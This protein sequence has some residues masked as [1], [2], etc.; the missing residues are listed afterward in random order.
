MTDELK[1]EPSI[2]ISPTQIELWERCERN[3][4]YDRVLK[5]RVYQPSKSQAIGIDVENRIQAAHEKKQDPGND[6]NGK[7]AQAMLELLPAFG[8]AGLLFQQDMSFPVPIGDG[9]R[10]ALVVGKKDLVISGV[11]V[12]DF[13]TTKSI[14]K[15][16]K[17]PAQLL[18]DIQPQ[19]YALD[20]YF[21]HGLDPIPLQWTYGQTEGTT[22]AHPVRVS[23]PAEVAH[24]AFDRAVAAATRM[25]ELKENVPQAH[26]TKPNTQACDAYGG[27]PHR[28]YCPARVSKL[29]DYLPK[30]NDVSLKDKLKASLGLTTA[31]VLP[32]EASPAQVATLGAVKAAELEKTN[33]A[34][35][36]ALAVGVNP[37]DALPSPDDQPKPVEVAPPPETAEFGKRKRRTKAEMEAV[38]ATEAL[39][40]T[41]N[42][43]AGKPIEPGEVVPRDVKALLVIDG[44]AVKG[45]GTPLE[46]LLRQAAIGAAKRAGVED[47]RLVDFG[48]GPAFV[49]M[50]FAEIW[51]AKQPTGLLTVSSRSPEAQAVLPWL[52]DRVDLVVR[53]V[54]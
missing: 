15:W 31:E 13:K 9:T 54:A 42:A 1:V 10:T 39:V 20:E 34:F 41:V 51:A 50:A 53:G 3:W 14:N 11:E 18:V 19:T 25:L 24:K 46:P 32:V 7:I 6:K 27:C 38:R 8:T 37:P 23:M 44:L 12:H 17:T 26:E 45:I 47:Y 35:S 4:F 48:K 30:G 28:A 16:A 40:E 52:I 22:R 5:L 2:K 21:K 49:L 43:P 36:A 29:S 33:E